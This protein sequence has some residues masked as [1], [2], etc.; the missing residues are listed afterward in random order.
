[1]IK[2]R[3]LRRSNQGPDDPFLPRRNH[4]E[5]GGFF[6]PW[7]VVVVVVDVDI[8]ASGERRWDLRSGL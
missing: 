4:P 6:V 8:D 5:G 2:E 7:F 3:R 1:M